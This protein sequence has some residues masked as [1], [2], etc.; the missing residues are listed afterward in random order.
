MLFTIGCGGGAHGVSLELAWPIKVD[1]LAVEAVV[2]LCGFD[3]TTILKML[4]VFG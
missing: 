2:V 4:P 3:I 1:V